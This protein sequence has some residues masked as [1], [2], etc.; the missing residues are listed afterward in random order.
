MLCFL[1]ASPIYQYNYETRIIYYGSSKKL[2]KK[3]SSTNDWSNPLN[4]MKADNICIVTSIKTFFVNSFKFNLPLDIIGLISEILLL[5]DKPIK[6]SIGINYTVVQIGNDEIYEF[7]SC[8]A[9]KLAKKNGINIYEKF[10]QLNI[11]FFRSNYYHTCAITKDNLLYMWGVEHYVMGQSMKV[12][13]V[14]KKIL[15]TNVVDV[16]CGVKH[17]AILT[18]ENLIYSWGSNLCGQLG[19][20]SDDPSMTEK[21]H[22]IFPKIIPLDDITSVNCGAYTSVAIRKNYHLYVW[23]YN[24]YGE[25][26][27]GYAG[28]NVFVPQKSSL[29]DVLSVTCTD[30]FMMAMTKNNCF[31]VWG[32]NT[33]NYLPMKLNLNSIMSYGVSH[34]YAYITTI[35]G[36]LYNINLEGLNHDQPIINKINIPKIKNMYLGYEDIIVVSTCNEIYKWAIYSD[37]CL[38]KLTDLP[39]KIINLCDRPEP[40]KN[41]SFLSWLF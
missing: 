22:E 37:N 21:I 12:V 13:A 39:S 30:L 19:H 18:G 17:T 11:D 41:K 7:G 23:G 4:Q 16:S 14:P 33:V 36:Q 8:P 20:I 10:S 35:D 3:Y 26:G 24:L 28:S 5:L 25:L 38:T 1:Q 34:K 9:R 31:Y 29:C 2:K 40:A 27:L 32:Y 15:I 6:I